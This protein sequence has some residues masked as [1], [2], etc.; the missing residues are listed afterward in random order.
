V[1]SALNRTL[2]AAPDRSRAA[3]LAEVSAG[4]IGTPIHYSDEALTD[5]LS[6]R[7]FV[8]VRRTPGGPSESETG[9]AVGQ[10]RASLEADRRWL[11]DT[12]EALSAAADR[13]RA[14]KAAL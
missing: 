1:V 4:I 2:A 13:L 11:A 5:L 3:V 10:S 12:R 8:S 7:H 9:P 14:R 6:P